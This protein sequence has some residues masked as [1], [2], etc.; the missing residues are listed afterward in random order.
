MFKTPPYLNHSLIFNVSGSQSA[1][2]CL[3]RLLQ[4]TQDSSQ[5]HHLECRAQSPGVC[6]EQAIHLRLVHSRVGI[7]ICVP[8]MKCVI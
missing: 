8:A 5:I 2:D 3:L 1:Q 6:Y 4:N 7:Q